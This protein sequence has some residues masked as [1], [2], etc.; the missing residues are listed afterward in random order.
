MARGRPIEY[1]AAKL[2]AFSRHEPNDVAGKD[3]HLYSEAYAASRLVTHV[4]EKNREEGIF[5][6]D[7]SSHAT[8][9]S[10]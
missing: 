5:S 2:R 1:L 4:D 10:N 7:A 9:E 3:L 8:S 6:P